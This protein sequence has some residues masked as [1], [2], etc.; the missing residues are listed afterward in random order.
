MTGDGVDRAAFASVLSLTRSAWAIA[1]SLIP[2]SRR[3]FA[4][5]AI[6]T[7]TGSPAWSMIAASTGM[8][9]AVRILCVRVHLDS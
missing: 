2:S 3:C 8:F 7:E 9:A 4:L 5:S 1:R 6:R